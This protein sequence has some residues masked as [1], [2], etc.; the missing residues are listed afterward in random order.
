MQQAMEFFEHLIFGLFALIMTAIA[1]IELL[2]RD[3]LTRAG[4]TGQLQSVVLVV[5][6]VL[7]ILAALRLFGGIFGLLITIFLIL[8]VVHVLVPGMQAPGYTHV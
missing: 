3:W 8:V 2:L 7:L 1:A 5:T 6:A 4:V